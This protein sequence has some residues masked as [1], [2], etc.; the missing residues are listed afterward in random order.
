MKKEMALRISLKERVKLYVV[1]TLDPIAK[2]LSDSL[3]ENINVGK[4]LR[5]FHAVLAFTFLVFTPGN[6]WL[7]V[8]FLVWF[9][10]T[11]SDCRRAG[12]K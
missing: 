11:L 2:T 3:E 6:A 4:L 10:L 12:I 9:A 5:I 8:L 1:N 7:S